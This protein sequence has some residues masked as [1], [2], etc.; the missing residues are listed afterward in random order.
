MANFCNIRL[1]AKQILITY[2]AINALIYIDRGALSAVI[3]FL[4]GHKHGGLNLSSSLAGTLGSSFILGYMVTAPMF[5]HYSQKYHPEYLMC[6][7]LTIWSVAVL[8]TGFSESYI[9][10]LISRTLTGIGEASFVCLAPP[11][12]MDIAPQDKKN[13]WI[14]L[15]YVAN[16]L[17]YALGFVFGNEIAHALDGWKYPFFFEFI[18]M[19]PFLILSLI[20]FKDPKLY[21]QGEDG[22]VHLLSQFKILVKNPVFVN[23]TLGNSAYTFTITAIS[24]WGPTY[25]ENNF[26]VSSTTATSSLGGITIIVG[27]LGTYLGSLLIDKKMKNFINNDSIQQTTKDSIKTE[28]CCLI[29]FQVCTLA[30]IISVTGVLINYLSTFLLGLALGEFILFLS[31]SPVSISL[32]TSIP[33]NLRGQ[34]NA[35][36]LFFSYAL[37]G[38]PAPSLI[39]I[40]FDVLSKT[41]GMT[42]AA[43][44][45]I[46]ASL[47]W[48]LAWRIARSYKGPNNYQW[49]DACISI[50]SLA[51]QDNLSVNSENPIQ[52]LVIGK[53]IPEIT[54]NATSFKTACLDPQSVSSKSA[55]YDAE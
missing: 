34:G 50:K 36:S 28:K 27:I 2:C 1:N 4:Q 16:V 29:S 53:D 32:M 52:Q 21:A 15:F 55:Y 13:L 24:F 7:G 51:I 10:L 3:P 39:G 9:F 49:K 37:G 54:S 5:A 48:F 40:F 6:I 45:L 43:A 44:W 23:L 11:V 38:F 33:S 8:M 25:I 41:W 22:N 46:W 31:I 17:G 26:K 30:F 20:N 19:T 12:I 42:I 18:L 47:F 35:V 14:G